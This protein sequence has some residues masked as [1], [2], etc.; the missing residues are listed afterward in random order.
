MDNDDSTVGGGL[1]IAVRNSICCSRVD[2]PHSE[3][4][5]IICVKANF[6][7]VSIYMFL[8]YIPPKSN[9]DLYNRYTAS[10][11]YVNDMMNHCDE[12]IC[13]GDFNLPHVRWERSV[14]DDLLFPVFGNSSL[15]STVIDN[16]HSMNLQQHNGTLNRNGKIL[17]LV[18]ST[19]NCDIAVIHSDDPV[20]PE[21]SHHP[22]LDIVIKLNT[23]NNL[24]RTNLY[25][26]NFKKADYSLL[27]QK[28]SLADWSCL[29]A[30]ENLDEAVFKF[31]SI[32]FDLLIDCVPV[33]LCKS[34]DMMPTWYTTALKKLKNLR[35][36]KWK[37]YCISKNYDDYLN[38]C[39]VRDEFT[40]KVQLSY[41]NYLVSLQQEMKIDPASFWRF[42]KTKQQSSTATTF[43]LNDTSSQ[44]PAVITNLF[45]DFFK[46]AFDNCDN[47]NISSNV[48]F[49]NV[50]TYSHLHDINFNVTAEDILEEISKIDE[51]YT[52]GPDG[53]PSIVLTKCTSLCTPLSTLFNKSIKDG[54]FPSA[55]KTS[56]IIPLH[57]K[58]CKENIENYR[59]IAR[60]SAIPKIFE[61]M[62]CK[63]LYFHVKSIIVDC[64][65]G[66]MKK[67]STTTNL[68]EFCNYCF[69]CF[70]KYSQVDCVF[71]DFSKAFDKLNHKVLL[72]KLR[73][74]GLN[75]NFLN[76][77]K[78]Y[79]EHRKYSVL[80][81][82]YQSE[83]FTVGSGVPQGSHL[84]PLLFILFINDLP[85]VIKYSEIQIYADDVKIF[86]DVNHLEDA[87]RLQTDLNAF[88]DWCYKNKLLLNVNKCKKM[89]F[90]RK[91]DL[92]DYNYKINNSELA[93]SEVSLDLGIHLDKKLDFRFHID[94]IVKKANKLLG[95]IK[96]QCKEFTDPYALKVLFVSFVRPILEYSSQLWSPHY[97]VHVN[98]LESVQKKF[99]SHA[100]RHLN[101]TNINDL[102]RYEYRLKLIDL[103][104]LCCR[105]KFLSFCFAHNLLNNHID[106]VTLLSMVNIRVPTRIYRNFEMIDIPH[107]RTNYL[108]HSPLNSMFNL[109]NKFNVILNYYVF[110]SKKFKT[111]FYNE[112]NLKFHSIANNINSNGNNICSI[113]ASRT[114]NIVG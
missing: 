23:S 105:R 109:Y 2:I 42:I 106:S 19:D 15:D 17:D 55:W 29:D 28:I 34:N 113:L 79:L 85:E 96:R 108:L 26:F 107:S 78:S 24:F 84:G 66:F 12:L 77:I 98:R 22:A 44:D 70:D 74:L 99:L 102:P 49:E 57:K 86:K 103:P 88:S 43:K 111:K 63:T 62:L 50:N 94:F 9:L 16:I 112:C 56:F 33:T 41:I 82:N 7:N 38:Y 101:W 53:I 87:L 37:K 8:A 21:E 46:N 1:L 60:L 59:P 13:L 6:A 32:L 31:Y 10:L 45:A 67:R 20:V 36:H 91:R 71:T 72:L 40:Q 73:K 4:L 27:N 90:S 97:D 25:K 76:W 18:F 14:E 54:Y 58:G 114:P 30:Y 80:Y 83:V 92:F 3:G 11:Q 95:L 65:H 47:N 39:Q 89:T 104:M 68:L 69:K 64:Q 81:N 93:D 35:N 52:C 5:E 48:N 110:K 51:S 100:L 75:D 61:A